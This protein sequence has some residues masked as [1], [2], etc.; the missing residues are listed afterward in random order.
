M[1]L[2]STARR[3]RAILGWI[4]DRLAAAGPISFYFSLL[5]LLVAYF[6]ALRL[7]LLLR[8]LPSARGLSLTQILYG[9]YLGAGADLRVACAIVAPAMLIGCLPR[10]GIGDSPRHRRLLLAALALML[11]FVTLLLM[12]E[13]EFFREFQTRFNLLAVEYLDQPKLVAGMLWYN[14]PV[15]WYAL[16]ATAVVGAF[17][18]A[19]HAMMRR[20]ISPEH[21]P[22]QTALDD[23][24][25]QRRP[26]IRLTSGSI[27]CAVALL[28]LAAGRPRAL[29]A[30]GG[31]V[32]A[33]RS[34]SEFVNQVSENGLIALA[35]V[36]RGQ[37]WPSDVRSPWLKQMPL[38][39]AR[40]IAANLIL[41]RHEKLLDPDQRTVLRID[42]D[43]KGQTTLKSGG[44]RPPNVVVVLM[45]SF[46]A[47]V[48]GAVGSPDDLTP[49]FNRI[50][51]GGIL[52]D[53]ALSNGTHTHQGVFCTL[54]GFPNLPGF[55]YLMKTSSAYQPFASLPRIFQNAGYHTMFLYAGDATWDNVEPFLGKQGVERFVSRKD[56]SHPV[57]EDAVWGV[58]DQDLLSR[59]NDEFD[60]AN[61]RGPFFATVL[62]V[63]NHAPFL[64][65]SPLPFAR[66]TDQGAMN[67]RYNGVRYAD[68]AIGQ[69]IDQAKKRDYFR[70]TLFVF[71]GDHG[72][73]VLPVMTRLQ[74]LYHHVPLLFYS[75]YLLPNSGTV[76]H[77]VASQVDI[78]PTVLGLLRMSTPMSF[79]GRNLFS[80][81]HRGENFAI[82][83]NADGREV[84]MVRGDRLL[85][86][87]DESKPHLY[88][89]DLSFPPSLEPLPSHQG[90]ADDTLAQMNRELRAYIESAITDLATRHVG[91]GT[92]YYAK[93]DE[94]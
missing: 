42:R 61:K 53:R 91:F 44:P 31:P 79:W 83:K 63:S 17:L 81:D 57:F 13:Y 40:Q 62:T 38:P 34:S 12:S 4:R 51:R 77:D 20:W 6:E 68:W 47:R 86:I 60:E 32:Q 46:S 54:L 87:D 37:I 52:F 94:Y 33:Q 39:Q 78:A 14:Y 8:N 43:V 89:Y 2:S 29:A 84:G 30:L 24:R 9:F 36:V 3:V 35:R 64:L 28:A 82:F 70:N 16:A 55:G 7:G 76:R 10:I 92:E 73:S 85:F 69:F 48:C 45:E 88:R 66:I 90:N 67:A 65:P 50:A 74:L 41:D 80:E 11:M 27:V 19:T 72:F 56:F 22:A 49:N 71:V 26:W 75:P 93:A 23:G 15:V 25:R 18:A 21:L 59:A 58:S 1:T 5:I